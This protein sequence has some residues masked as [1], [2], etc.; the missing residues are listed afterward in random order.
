MRTGELALAAGARL[1][2]HGNAIAV[3]NPLRNARRGIGHVPISAWTTLR[4]VCFTRNHL[5]CGGLTPLL[6]QGVVAAEVTRR[7]LPYVEGHEIQ[8]GVK[9]PPSK[10]AFQIRS[11]PCT[12]M[13]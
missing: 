1:S 13:P 7:I 9:P 5:E 12:L 6:I 8:G 11:A 3:P 4:D 10:S 2:S